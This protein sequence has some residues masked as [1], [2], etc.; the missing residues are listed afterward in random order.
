M[1]VTTRLN[2]NG[3]AAPA[4][5]PEQVVPPHVA[6][7]PEAAPEPEEAETVPQGLPSRS[8]IQPRLMS[9]I[10]LYG[11]MALIALLIGWAALTTIDRTV[12]ANGRVVPTAQL[13]TVSNL[14]G[15]IIE[16]IDVSAGDI[17]KEGD[18]LLHLDQTLAQ[19]E[20]GS[21]ASS[22]A[23]LNAKI[24]RLRAE[25]AGDR[26]N[27]PTP[28]DPASREQVEIERALYRSRQ[29][30]LSSITMAGQARIDQS[31]R[32]VAEAQANYA[33]AVASRD[34]AR[35]QVDILRPLV[36][37]GIEPRLTLVQSERQANVAA[38][39]AAAAQAGIARSQAAVGE[40]VAALAQARQDWRSQAAAEL[41]GARAEAASRA[42]V[43]PALANRLDRTVL[44]APM[45]GQV[46]RVLVST[47][48]GTVR[49]G[50][51]LVEIV[52]SRSG[53]TVEAMVRPQDIAWIH[54][55]QRA[56]VKV[57]AYDYAIYGGIEGEVIGI[58]PDS[59]IDERTGE[60]QYIV[61]VRTQ[62]EGLKT[63]EGVVLPVTA[64][65]LADVNLI[66][67]RR[68]VLNYLLRPFTR[69][70]ERAFRE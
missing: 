49:P 12:Y 63:R 53:L 31:R 60:A 2:K 6:P 20:F 34:A 37:R 14:E 39:Q 28:T 51:P 45:D 10:L 26:P 65:M 16:K 35:Q 61:K 38:E 11:V 21:S 55:G 67:D 15:G 50:E 46:N 30:D 27:F 62:A 40:A 7:A 1:H 43:Q 52:P 48:G 3:T 64:G 9:N 41:A 22:L 4:N 33:G 23:A 56:L 8:L 25:I 47:V 24:E 70:S 19:S 17:V 18:P 66:G 29:A 57:S 13:Q 44:R 54:T 68:T 58:S 69:L 32:A 59:I 42:E 5:A 36:E